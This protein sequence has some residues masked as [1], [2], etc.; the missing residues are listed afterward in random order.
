MKTACHTDMLSIMEHVGSICLESKKLL[1]E[2]F[3]LQ[4]RSATEMVVFLLSDT[5]RMYEDG[6]ALN[7]PIAYAMKGTTHR[8]I[9]YFLNIFLVYIKLVITCFR[10]CSTDR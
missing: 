1:H 4:R 2:C 6:I 9:L 3:E 5:D 8:F 10:I 7:F